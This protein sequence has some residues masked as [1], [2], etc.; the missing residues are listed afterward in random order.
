VAADVQGWEAYG[1][2]QWNVD[3]VRSFVTKLFRICDVWDLVLPFHFLLFT[4]F[5]IFPD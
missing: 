5:G 2:L 3:I 4:E 1:V